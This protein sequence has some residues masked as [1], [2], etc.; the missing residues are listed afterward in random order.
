MHKGP[1]FSSMNGPGRWLR[2]LHKGKSQVAARRSGWG[3]AEA[4][5]RVEPI[6]QRAGVRQQEALYQS[7]WCRCVPGRRRLV[8]CGLPACG[9]SAR[10]V[11]E[12]CKKSANHLC[13]E[14]PGHS[15]YSGP[16]EGGFAAWC[17]VLGAWWRFC[18]Q[19]TRLA[20][21]STSLADGSGPGA[22][23]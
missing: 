5:L 18:C 14:Q 8:V 21:P 6:G 9:T 16:V 4:C 23:V 15:F 3:F 1:S 7:R 13:S 20:T 22:T 17:L 12:V 2:R 19:T 11:G 10:V